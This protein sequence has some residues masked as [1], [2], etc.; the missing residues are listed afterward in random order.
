MTIP[1]T[2]LYPG[3]Q[4]YWAHSASDGPELFRYLLAILNSTVGHWQIATQS[5]KYQ[6]GYAR[7]EAATLKRLRVPA[8]AS[9]PPLAMRRI[10]FLVEALVGDPE[11]R[12]AEHELDEVVCQIFG[13]QI[14]EFTGIPS[15]GSG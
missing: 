9:V 11:N 4:S 13:V 1:E 7:L 12:E 8:P 14:E 10:Q 3:R 6:R 5:H 15:P 2:T